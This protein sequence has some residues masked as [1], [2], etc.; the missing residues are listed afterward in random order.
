MSI[1]R[2]VKEQKYFVAS[3][4]LFNDKRLSWEAR[5]IMA[6]LLSKPDGWQCHNYDLVN[7]SAAGKH[8]VQRVLKE[9]KEFGYVHRYQESDGAK[10]VWVTE[11]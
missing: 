1:V 4:V 6:Y 9:L 3:N 10:I 5:G 11:V 8:V 7:Q 2:T